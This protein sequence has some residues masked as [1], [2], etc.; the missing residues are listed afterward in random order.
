[1]KTILSF[2]LLFCMASLT[3]FAQEQDKPKNAIGIDLQPLFGSFSNVAETTLQY[4]RQM[5][6]IAFRSGLSLNFLS[7]EQTTDGGTFSETSSRG[8]TSRIGA[9]RQ[10]YF[11]KLG[12][13]IG[14]DIAYFQTYSKTESVWPVSTLY[15]AGI[16]RT[17]ITTG[18]GIGLQP[19]L[20]MSYSFGRHFSMSTEAYG[21]IGRKKFDHQST[22]NGDFEEELDTSWSASLLRGFRFFARVHF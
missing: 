20:A 13:Q 7:D 11:D 15:P 19:V 4:E 5:K 21:N 2:A 18:R 8:F 16:N 17:N 6:G 10:L 9:A 12:I 1:M 3:V 14:A 22:G